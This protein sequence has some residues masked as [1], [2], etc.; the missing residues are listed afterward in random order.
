VSEGINRIDHPSQL[1]ALARWRLAPPRTREPVHLEARSASPERVRSWEAQL[2]RHQSPCGCDQGALG[3][4]V[5]VVGYLLFLVLRPGGWGDP[6][7][8]EFLLGCAVALV[9]TSVG[10]LIGVLAARHKLR[11]VI[12]EIQSE[13]KPPRP[14]ERSF[15]PVDEGGARPA[16]RC[17]G[18][19]KRLRLPGVFG[20]VS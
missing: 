2:T 10:K 7:W 5:G 9:T 4:V 8:H 20:R 19:R 15:A 3:L 11:R 17:C 1:A 18:D 16:T 14:P 13:W 6:G 12:R